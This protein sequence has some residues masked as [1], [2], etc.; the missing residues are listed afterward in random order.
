MYFF[1]QQACTSTPFISIC[2]S[3]CT[4]SS[5]SSSSKNKNIFM[6]KISWNWKFVLVINFRVFYAWHAP[7]IY[8]K[9][10]R[11]SLKSYTILFWITQNSFISRRRNTQ[12]KS[13]IS[14]PYWMGHK[15]ESNH[16]WPNSKFYT[17][18]HITH[19]R[20]KMSFRLIWFHSRTPFLS[21]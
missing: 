8:S 4:L 16:Q 11:K 10:S 21:G 7:F 12:K 13:L 19:S 17:R 2:I 15:N 20:S 5:V 6:N 1:M 14:Y 3:Y 18:L 9:F